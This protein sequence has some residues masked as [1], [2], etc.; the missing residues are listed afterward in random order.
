MRLISVIHSKIL[1]F[2]LRSKYFYFMNSIPKNSILADFTT[3]LHGDCSASSNEEFTHY[4]A[5]YFWIFTSIKES[6]G[7]LSILDLGGKKLANGILS[8]SHSITS[9]NL[10]K[11]Y[12]TISKV[13]YV[14]ADA[15]QKLPFE[16][17]SFNTF[18]SPV[19]LNLIG[20]GRY[21]DAIDGDAIPRFIK[22]LTR[23]ISSDGVLYISMVFGKSLIS[24]NNHISFKMSDILELFQNW[25][26]LDYLID[27]R[28]ENSC[29]NGQRF[30][31]DYKYVEKHLSNLENV[32]F[33]K[34]VRTRSF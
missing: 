27:L 3:V 34:F 30:T 33:L 12:D 24:F 7:R 21:G 20:L 11:P 14:Q 5:F 26:L 18:I 10:L 28:D 29:L 31:K 16:S 8:T 13:Q 6:S 17:N 19:S 25:E 1:R 15:T 9:L 22:E 32:I 4:D 23:V 2:R